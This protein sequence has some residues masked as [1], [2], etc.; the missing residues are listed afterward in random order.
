[1]IQRLR[2]PVVGVL[3][4]IAAALPFMLSGF[5]LY[6]FT[7]V[8][9]YA[10]AL[11][12]LNMLT[13]YSGQISLGHGAFYA[14]G[15]FRLLG[16]FA[17]L[18]EFLQYLLDVASSTKQL[19]LAPLYQ[20]DGKA[21][22][23]E[24][25]LDDWRGY[26]DQR[27]V[28]IGNQAASHRQNDVFGE[29]VIALAPFFLDARFREQVTEPVLDLVTRLAR[30]AVVEP[31]HQ[32]GVVEIGDGIARALSNFTPHQTSAVNPRTERRN[33]RLNSFEGRA[34]RHESVRRHERF[35]SQDGPC[36]RE[37]GNG[38]RLTDNAPSRSRD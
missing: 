27:P 8:F 38:R 34:E 30:K 14:L 6:Q 10:I 18:E 15:A 3:L 19:D 32:P 29:M 13:G 9:V 2:V 12:G 33:S 37:R 28:R 25:I 17:E 31:R 5:R 26:C 23:A 16:Q 1:M 20:L 36:R 7:Q 22:P 35:N 24:H 4:V 11:L 21:G